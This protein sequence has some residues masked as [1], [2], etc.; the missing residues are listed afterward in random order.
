MTEYELGVLES[1]QNSLR[2]IV[3]EMKE[4]NKMKSKEL[5]KVMQILSSRESQPAIDPDKKV[6]RKEPED[7]TSTFGDSFTYNHLEA[8]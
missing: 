2:E 3:V 6:P 7:N 5:D 4:S 8:K 1:I